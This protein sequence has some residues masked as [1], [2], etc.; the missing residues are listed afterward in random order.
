ML[1]PEQKVAELE[2]ILQ[3][4]DLE[5]NELRLQNE[6]PPVDGPLSVRDSV[7]QHTARIKCKHHSMYNLNIELVERSLSEVTSISIDTLQTRLREVTSL[8]AVVE[9]CLRESGA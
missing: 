4:K 8:L 7:S 2:S 3:A 1:R 5:L 6:M 9:Q